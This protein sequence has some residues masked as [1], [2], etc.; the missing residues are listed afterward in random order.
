MS[1]TQNQ[2]IPTNLPS[3]PW[4]PGDKLDAIPLNN[5][6]FAV[7][8]LINNLQNQI[9]DLQATSG[10]GNL[11]ISATVD[12]GGSA[13]VTPGQYVIAPAV[14]YAFFI[15]S[16]IYNV[17][18]SGGSFTFTVYNNGQPVAGL[19]NV[20]VASPVDQTL[21]I[22]ASDPTAT[23]QR[24]AKLSFSVTNVTGTPSEGYLSING[25]T[26]LQQHP[27]VGVSTGIA[28]G[29]S[30]ALASGF[31]SV[32]NQAI[33]LGQGTSTV[34][35]VGVASA[36]MTGLAQGI[37]DKCIALAVAVQSASTLVLDSATVGVLD[38]NPL[39]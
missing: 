22:N 25:V 38:V 24:G 31:G 32:N 16:V 23:I 17:G 30:S 7:Q 9:T 20:V 26:V 21:G 39:G 15:T 13:I 6:F 12:W 35:G 28:S 36:Q 19:V 3:F 5:Q 10:N 1:S 4:T 18:S 29:T 14:A 2:I 27:E 33:M 37:N 8:N 34:V 11:P